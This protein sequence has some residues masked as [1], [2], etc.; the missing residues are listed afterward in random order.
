M[1]GYLQLNVVEAGVVQLLAAAVITEQLLAVGQQLLQ[2][3]RQLRLDQL[4]QP[5]LLAVILEQEREVLI[6]SEALQ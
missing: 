4:L 2:P 5:Q 6:G 1:S 3:R